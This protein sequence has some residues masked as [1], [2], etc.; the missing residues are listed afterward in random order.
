MA[1]RKAE[2]R[3]RTLTGQELTITL[4]DAGAGEI[5]DDLAPPAGAPELAYPLEFL[6]ADLEAWL[7]GP[8]A[9]SRRAV[10][11]MYEALR[12]GGDLSLARGPSD[13]DLG[14]V[15]LPALL[16]GFERGELRA[17]VRVPAWDIPRPAAPSQPEPAAEAL[18]VE[19]EARPR[20]Q[21]RLRVRLGDLDAVFEPV[22]GVHGKKQR[23][24]ALGHYYERFT[25]ST[26]ATSTE[27]FERC[28]AYWRAKRERA[29][30]RTFADDPDFEADL[31][32]QVRRFVVEGGELPAPGA[33]TRIRLPGAV[34]CESLDELDFV[35]VPA[36]SPLPSVRFHRETAM[37]DGHGAL[38]RIPIV[39]KLEVLRDGSWVAAAGED[40]HFQLIPPFYDDP[41]A[42]LA[43]V[44]ALRD[45]SARPPCKGWPSGPDEVAGPQQFITNEIAKAFD[46]HDPQRYNARVSL[47]GKRGGAV[48]GGIFDRLPAP[49]FPDMSAP[50]TS[51]R[52]HAVQVTTNAKGEAGV[53]FLPARTAGDRYR[54]RVFLDPNDGAASDGTEP[55]AVG[56]ET[57]RLCVWRHILWSTYLS[58]PPPQYPPA[59]SVAG[60]QAR[61]R[62]LGYDVGEIDGEAGPRTHE[63]VRAFQHAHHP[64]PHNGDPGHA[65]TQAE[66]DRAV[67]DYVDGGESYHGFGPAIPAPRF[68]TA[69]EEMRRMYCELEIEPEASGG[70]AGASLSPELHQAALRW[71]IA[72]VQRQ[73]PSKITAP[74]DVAAMFSDDFETP[75]LFEIRH[76]E[77]YNRLRR[78]GFPPATPGKG[79]TRYWYDAS[80]LLDPKEHDCD[81]TGLLL[82]FLRYISGRASPERPPGSSPTGYATPGLTVITALAASRLTWV[83]HEHGQATVP[84]LGNGRNSGFTFFDRASVVFGGAT[85]HGRSGIYRDDSFTKTMVHEMGHILLLR[86]QFETQTPSRFRE[87]HDSSARVVAPALVPAPVHYDRCL[88]GYAPC[89]GELCGKCHLKLRG[90]DISRMPTS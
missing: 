72:E 40:V 84:K 15:G 3:L 88:M 50:A 43:D 19:P 67:R 26:G 70:G 13:D 45:R 79:F 90:W 9:W 62:V 21:R 25:A 86:H 75:F 38:G 54:M 20:E 35:G 66:I 47:G 78:P 74:R 46:E 69:V 1:K 29:R 65:P 5:R 51:P 42:E 27:A 60:V 12:G 81:R 61:L 73:P 71:A 89:E 24:Q 83:T 68:A 36:G 59:E 80:I 39:A 87:D 22:T 55:N 82:F 4:G 28:L 49:A 52:A 16:E 6:P 7:A 32:D 23:L 11:E 56:F 33:E 48:L 37:W 14:R 41:D 30:G 85:L 53:L 44:H 8:D 18:P 34:S 10:V 77:H 17:R 57:G 2:W 64:L 76:P 58:K 63:A 31:Q